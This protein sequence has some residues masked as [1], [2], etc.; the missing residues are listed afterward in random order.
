MATFESMTSTE[1]AAL[2]AAARAGDKN[3][4][5]ELIRRYEGLVKAVT[6][7]F[8][9]NFA[10]SGD[11]VQNTWLRL[12][13]RAETIREPEKL[14]GWLATTARRECLAIIRRR[15]VEN[16]QA[17][18]DCDLASLDPTP[19]AVVIA[20]EMRVCVRAA[21]AALPGRP[22]ALIDALYYRPESTYADVGSVTGMPVGSIGPTRIRTLRHL[23]RTLADWAA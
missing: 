20:A 10:D 21:T 18:A 16:Q 19:E 5:P 22:R 1:N 12:F 13:E 17:L 14:G 11:A 7:H 2:F 4:W 8:M 15:R 6:S 9:M 3:A 23:R